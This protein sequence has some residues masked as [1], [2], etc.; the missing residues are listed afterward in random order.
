[1]ERSIKVRLTQDLT[2]YHPEL[3]SGVEGVTVGQYGMWSRGSDRFVG[4]RFPEIGTF[5]ILCEKLEIIDE[6]YL[7]EAEERDK[8]KWELLKNA[9]NVVRTIGPKGGFKYLSYE[10]LDEKGIPNHVSNGDR[11]AAEKLIAFFRKHGIEVREDR[12]K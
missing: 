3:V 5:D 8:R 11:Q 12:L 4:V 6:E 2:R 10:Y 1:V 9:K 7:A